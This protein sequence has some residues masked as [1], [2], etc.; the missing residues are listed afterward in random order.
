MLLGLLVMH[1]GLSAH[2]VD[3]RHGD[4]VATLAGVGMGG[5]IGMNVAHAALP[6]DLNVTSP[7]AVHLTDGEHEGHGGQM[8]LAFLRSAALMLLILII[9]RVLRPAG[10]HTTTP[11]PGSSGGGRA[12][13]RRALPVHRP[14]LASLCVLRL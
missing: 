10:Q 14:S 6:A 7:A 3:H 9:G 2:I 5:A 8:C 13:P 4:G 11:R 1:G 12:P